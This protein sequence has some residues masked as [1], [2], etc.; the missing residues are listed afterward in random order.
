MSQTQ[1]LIAQSQGSAIISKE[2]IDQA[3]NFFAPENEE[4]HVG[5]IPE[6]QNGS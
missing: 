6:F 1:K 2:Q 4:L 3:D 5:E